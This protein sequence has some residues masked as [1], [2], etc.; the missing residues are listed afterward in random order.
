MR[1]EAAMTRKKCRCP[2]HDRP[3]YRLRW[4][5]R[6]AW[7]TFAFTGRSR[8]LRYWGTSFLFLAVTQAVIALGI[9]DPVAG[10][11]AVAAVPPGV[12]LLA[13]DDIRFRRRARHFIQKQDA[14]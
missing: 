4:R 2:V 9:T 11:T 1:E 6:D 13:A 7:R 5:L 8:R 14:R 3:R 12:A 10:W